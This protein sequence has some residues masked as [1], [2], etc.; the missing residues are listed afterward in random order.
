MVLSQIFFKTKS[1]LFGQI[2]I[3]RPVNP[4]HLGQPLCFD[5]RRQR[6]RACKSGRRHQ[7]WRPR[8]LAFRYLGH[9][10]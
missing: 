7:E 8:T 5:V 1:W 2:Y 4:I 10:P 9:L 6:R 3:A